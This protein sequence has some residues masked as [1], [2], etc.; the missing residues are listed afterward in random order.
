MRDVNFYAVAGPKLLTEQQYLELD[1]G[2]RVKH[3]LIGGRVVA[4]AGARLIHN[5]LQSRLTELVGPQV[6]PQGCRPLGSDQRVRANAQNYFY[7]DLTILCGEPELAGEDVLL[8]PVAVFEIASDST[9]RRDRTAKLVQ[10]QRVPGLRHIVFIEPDAREVEWLSRGEDGGWDWARV[11]DAND[12][13]ALDG[14]RVVLKLG[15]LFGPLP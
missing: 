2:G 14:P 6:R 8:N 10:Y 4:M 1:R 11:T 15:E 9:R 3:E 5:D 7:P 12:E 13:L